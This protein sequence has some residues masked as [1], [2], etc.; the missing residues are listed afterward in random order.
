MAT[1]TKQGA[2]QV[3]QTLDRIAN[4]FQTEAK[5]LGVNPRIANDFALRC[6][7]LSD[8]IEKRAGTRAASY[9]EG[10]N[11]TG[12][13]VEPP[14]FDGFDA[15]NI[16]D[17]KAGPL[18][19]VDSDEPWMQGEFTQQELRELRGLQQ[20]GDLGP[21]VLGP[22]APMPAKQASAKT[23]ALWGQFNSKVAGLG[24]L[25]DS[26][27]KAAFQKL[28]AMESELAQTQAEIQRLAGQLVQREKQLGDA[29]KKEREA[30][31]NKLPDTLKGQGDSIHAMSDLLLKYQKI[32]ASNPP[33]MEVVQSGV[34]AK[35]EAQFGEQV[36]EALAEIFSVV[37]EENTGVKKAVAKFEFEVLAPA[38]KLAS[39][40]NKQA[41]LMD[42]MVGLKNF[43]GK[44]FSPLMGLINMATNAIK[45]H[46]SDTQKA[47]AVWEKAHAEAL[48]ASKQASGTHGFNLTK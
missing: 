40:Q 15:N 12:L 30:F 3:T 33:K 20:D 1:I 47:F 42:I 8:H 19:M 37:I 16:G 25:T 34:L 21:V 32:A 29:Y 17:E 6:D 31:S 35:A 41:G 4:L 22:R 7:L 48:K 11:E 39:A 38:A 27:I 44:L 23:A 26:E 13:S 28:S 9:E 10:D 24:K 43:F 45:G 14:P 46:V 5:T 36:R 18:E 2:R